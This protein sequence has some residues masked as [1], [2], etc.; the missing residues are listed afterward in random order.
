MLLAAFG[1]VI[2][3]GVVLISGRDDPDES[4]VAET[5]FFVEPLDVAPWESAPPNASR[6]P[7]LGGAQRDERDQLAEWARSVTENTDIPERAVYAYVRAEATLRAEQPSC[8]LSWA[9]LAGIGREESHHGQFGG[10]TLAA[11]GTVS[12]PIIGPP[13]DGSEGVKEIRDTDGGELD[14]DTTYDRAVG[15][16]QFLPTTWARWGERA[17]GDGAAADPQN[18]DD[19]ALSAARYLCASGTDLGTGRGWWQAVLT[20]NESVSYGKDVFSGADA[21]ARAS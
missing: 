21:Y 16:M 7:E 10:A 9:T 5:G 8:R 2:V 12:P 18:V 17:S 3:G 15:P 19:A 11:D 14:G 13:L 20:Y 6:P 4:A 1:A